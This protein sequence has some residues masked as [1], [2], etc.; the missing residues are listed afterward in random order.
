MQYQRILKQRNSLLKLAATR[1]VLDRTLLAA[2]DQQLLPLATVIYETRKHF[3][4]Q[5][6][7]ALQQHY[8]YF[9]DAPE[10]I[11]LDY[12]SEVA[13]PDFEQ[14]YLASFQQDLAAQRTTLGIH[15]DDFDFILNGYPL[16]KIG[17]QGQQKSFIVALRLAQFACIYQACQIKPLLLLDDI[18]D[19]LDEERVGRLMQLI[20][21][22][23]FGQVWI[24]DARG[25]RSMDII[26]PMKVDKA[27]FKIEGGK[28][29]AKT[30]LY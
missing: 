11:A 8:R 6:Q 28:L 5:F 23:R 21:Q 7:P 27:L 14:L 9:V 30:S 29:V 20:I 3:M 12:V 13:S 25:I 2:Y 10:E 1:G 15:R 26:Q 22:Q 16:K 17:S 19:K 4:G 18:F 24:T